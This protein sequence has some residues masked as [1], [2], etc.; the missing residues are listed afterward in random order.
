MKKNAAK[1]T[2]AWGIFTTGARPAILDH[3]LPIYWRK[4]QAEKDCPEGYVVRKIIITHP[5]DQT[6]G[7][8]L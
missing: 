7:G 5:G 1:K 3:R 8:K 6:T 4:N 2:E